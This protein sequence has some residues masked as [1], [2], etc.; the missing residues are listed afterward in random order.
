MPAV[1]LF[2]FCIMLFPTSII[3]SKTPLVSTLKLISFAMGAFA[4]MLGFQ[5]TGH[6]KT[7]WKVWF[8]SF[9]LYMVLS[10]ALIYGLGMGYERNNLGFQGILSHPQVTGSIMAISAAWFS[11]L[12]LFGRDR[13]RWLWLGAALSWAFIFM[14]QARTGAVAAA[15]GFALSFLIYLF[16]RRPIPYSGR[17]VKWGFGISLALVVLMLLIPGRLINMAMGFLQKDSEAANVAS[18]FEESRAWGRPPISSA[19]NLAAPKP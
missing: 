9:F 5:R 4:I 16:L 12:L 1:C 2:V 18:A 19:C 10:S 14:S 13:S 8:T 15:G 3:T 17:L 7:Y 11:A 6:Y